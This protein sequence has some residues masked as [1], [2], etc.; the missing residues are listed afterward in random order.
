MRARSR[1][2]DQI[3]R[4]VGAN[5]KLLHQVS[6]RHR[7]RTRQT[8]EAVNENA[9]LVGAGFVDE[10]EARLEEV[11]DVFAG[12]VVEGQRQVL[13]SGA[14][15]DVEVSR[16]GENVADV[17]VLV[18][19]DALRG[20]H[21]S[22][23]QEVQHAIGVDLVPL[24]SDD[25]GRGSVDGIR[26]R[27]LQQHRPV[28]EADVDFLG[29]ALEQLGTGQSGDAR[30]LGEE[31]SFELRSVDEEVDGE[32]LQRI[33]LESHL[34]QFRQAELF[35]GIGIDVVGK[36]RDLVVVQQDP[37]Q[38][39][40][41]EDGAGNCYELVLHQIEH[42]ELLHLQKNGVGKQRDVVVAEEQFAE[43]REAAQLLGNSLDLKSGEIAARRLLGDA[44][45]KLALELLLDFAH[46]GNWLRKLLFVEV[47]VRA[48]RLRRRSSSA[49][50]A[51]VVVAT[52]TTS[53]ALCKIIAH[54][55]RRAHDRFAARNHGEGEVHVRML[56]GNLPDC[57]TATS[58][59]DGTT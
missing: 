20:S 4:V 57:P 37:L 52:A 10:L 5:S 25:A 23:V 21:R 31:H 53:L 59:D 41:L 17:Q 34:E 11:A 6:H 12:K 39:A 40:Q 43:P 50:V 2:F 36:A 56:P 22:E 42:F 29:A 48:V 54:V 15:D 16:G 26:R 30:V 27:G 51:V 1:L 24:E 32:L 13:H 45:K 58:S 18:D 3:E 19:F 46:R 9:L 49:R 8:R 55:A 14:E 47:L 35:D 44:A 33:P 7:N 38:G 28:V